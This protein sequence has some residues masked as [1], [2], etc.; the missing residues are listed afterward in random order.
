MPTLTLQSAI[1][2]VPA[3]AWAV[4]VS[5]GADSIALLSLLRE[6][7]DL[8]LCVVHL[9]HETRGGVSCQD[10]KFVQQLANEWK[11]PIVI[12]QRSE[13]EP[14]LPSLPS[15]RS[16]RFRALRLE[17]FRQVVHQ[18]KLHGVLLAHHADDQAE[19]ILQRLLRGSGLHGLRGMRAQTTV[20]GLLI[21]RPLLAINRDILRQMLIERGIAWREDASN[22]SMDQQRNRIRR[23]LASH[24]DLS[25][26][27]LH[28]GE[29]CVRW[30]DWLA[31]H[32]PCLPASFD[33]RELDEL[34]PPVAEFAAL[35]WLSER[36]DHHQ[37]IPPDAAHRLIDMATDAASPPR[38]NFPGGLLVRRRGGRIFSETAPALEASPARS[39]ADS[40]ASSD[41]DKDPTA[42]AKAGS[43]PRG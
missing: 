27:L 41:L 32:A 34:P 42:A 24:P 1:A 43:P 36:I 28:L 20:A 10:A 7:A 33:P 11:L 37:E 3:G 19:T 18:R 31:Q 15:N 29:S 16:A 21:L 39:Q 40:L 30:S 9:D 4:G 8:S 13:L 38:Q 5:G 25:Q 17:L 14:A 6:R 26:H 12:R 35:R 2:A 22:Q 23:L